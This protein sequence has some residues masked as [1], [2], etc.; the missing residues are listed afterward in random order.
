[1]LWETIL[2]SFWL[3]LLTGDKV[4][5]FALEGIDTGKRQVFVPFLKGR[6]D[7]DIGR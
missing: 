2:T 3:L 5:S 7:K 1:M 4:W 6:T